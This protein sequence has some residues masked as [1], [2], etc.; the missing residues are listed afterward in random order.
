[1]YPLN[2]LRS[3]AASRG[4]STQGTASLRRP[5][6]APLPLHD[7]RAAKLLSRPLERTAARTELQ[8]NLH[9]IRAPRG[10]GVDPKHT[11]LG[12][13]ALSARIEPDALEAHLTAFSRAANAQQKSALATGGVSLETFLQTAARG[14][15][16]AAAGKPV[17]YAAV[18]ARLEAAG[19]PRELDRIAGALS[20]PDRRRFFEGKLSAIELFTLSA[21]ARATWSASHAPAPLPVIAR[22]L[23]QEGRLG[24]LKALLLEL[25]PATRA[26]LEAGRL[27]P[28]AVAEKLEDRKLATSDVIVIGAGMAG[29]AAAHDLREQGLSVT[30]LEARDRIGGRTFTDAS[31]IGSPFDAGAAWLH[32]AAQ[33]PLTPIAEQLGFSVVLDDAPSLAFDGVSDP[34]EEG[35][36]FEAALE[37]TRDRWSGA[38]EQGLDIS[39]ERAGIG[40]GKWDRTAAASLGP[41]SLG[42]EPSRGSTK[43]FATIMPEVGDKLVKE[44]LGSVVASFGHGLPIKLDTPV[45]QVSWGKDGVRVSAGGREYRGKKL[46]VTV[47][48]GVLQAN[49]IKFD[50][51]LPSWKQEAISKIPMGDFDKIAL[52][53]DRNVFAGTPDTAHARTFADEDGSIEFVM[54]PFGQ[55]AVIG[56]VGGDTARRLEAQGEEAA[57]SF[58]LDRLEKMYGPQVRRSVIKSFVTHWSSDPWSLGAYTAALPGYQHMREKLKKPVDDTLFFAGEAMS[59]EWAECVP[60]AYLTGKE[61]AANIVSELASHKAKLKKTGT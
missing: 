1:M 44:G 11:L 42:V 45:S 54:R 5:G 4:P 25:D 23:Q 57:V 55:D 14:H 6:P 49:K 38:G 24:E 56:L 32:S 37:A 31:A 29:L 15:F 17:T 28:R 7:P 40:S 59:Q 52:A 12:L 43:D 22:E 33:N 13:E 53:F 51:P 16:G 19:A 41:L 50:P 58:A 26:A 39:L 36:A 2:R 46:L 27:S 9:S 8:G 10:P 47:P 60:G 20:S 30:V 48:T 61:A 18:K 35:H 34:I 3:P 21:R